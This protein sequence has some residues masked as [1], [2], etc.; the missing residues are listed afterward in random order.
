MINEKSSEMPE[1]KVMN[2]AQ[3]YKVTPLFV[4]DLKKVLADVAYV[5]AQKF[6]ERIT[7]MN[8]IMP[9]SAVQEMIRDLGCLPYKYVSSFMNIINNKDNFVK[10]FEPLPLPQQ[11]KN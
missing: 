2:Y 8:Y 5:D 11:Q 4:N 7:S 6:F 10:Y 1:P 3:H 9:I